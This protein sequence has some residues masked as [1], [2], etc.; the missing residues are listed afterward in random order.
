MLK[1]FKPKTVTSNISVWQPK[2]VIQGDLEIE[3]TKE[4]VKITIELES[5]Q[6]GTIQPESAKTILEELFPE[7]IKSLDE[8]KHHDYFK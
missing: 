2:F 3:K 4:I 7:V 5:E 8:M 6:I 1:L